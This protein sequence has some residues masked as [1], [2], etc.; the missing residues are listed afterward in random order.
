MLATLGHMAHLV[1]YQAADGVQVFTV[2]RVQR[3]AERF[4]HPLNRGVATDA[5]SFISQRV[6]IAFVFGHIVKL[7]FNL[8]D[9]LFQHIFNGDQPRRAAKLVYHDSQMVTV[10]SEFAQQI[11]QP[12]ALGHKHRRAQQGAHIQLGRALQLEQ[13]FGHQNTND[14]L[15]VAVIHRKARVRGVNNGVHQLVGGRINI[16]NVHARRSY[17]HIARCHISHADHALQHG[18]AFGPNDVVALGLGQGFNQLV[19]AVGAG[20]QKFG[21]LLQKAAFVDVLG[22]LEMRRRLHHSGTKFC[23]GQAI[24]AFVL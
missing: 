5:V 10:A 24:A 15:A 20:V 13:I 11:V 1:R 22:G 16:D 4:F 17:H 7:V 21:Q 3:N 23:C 14:V 18:A 8:A 9:N 19:F 6:N 12:L 2:A